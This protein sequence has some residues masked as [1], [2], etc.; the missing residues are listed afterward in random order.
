M[1][2][3]I[4][5]RYGGAGRLAARSLLGMMLAIG[6]PVQADETL[7]SDGDAGQGGRIVAPSAKPAE[8]AVL[9][10]RLRQLGPAYVPRTEHRLP[11]GSPRYLNRLVG[12]ASPYLLQH[13][14]NPVDWFP[15]GAEAFERARQLDRPVFLSIGYATCH[16]CHVMERE[17]FE[18]ETIAAFMNENFVSIKV[19]REQLPDVDALF[20]T[21]V[22]M[23]TGSGGWPMSSFVDHDG[24]PFYGGTYFPPAQFT[25]LLERV[26]S[27]WAQQ[28]SSLLDE[29]G[30]ISAAIARINGAAGQARKVGSGELTVARAQLLSRLDEEAG[31]FGGA[32]KFP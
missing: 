27:A 24:R 5:G 7:P 16:W 2:D 1:N 30:R 28:R 9:L 10:E 31:G 4:V 15:W 32:P 22:Q 19:D 23:I 8:R 12:E 21:A 14:H 3:A 20:M 18:N 26:S 25:D 29:A 13:A 6:S 11:D 17:S